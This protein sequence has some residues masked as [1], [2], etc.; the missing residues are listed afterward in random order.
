MNYMN[1]EKF[2]TQ[3]YLMNGPK[4]KGFDDGI[5]YYYDKPKYNVHKSWKHN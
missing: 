3:L 2:I 1:L 5:N 4:Q